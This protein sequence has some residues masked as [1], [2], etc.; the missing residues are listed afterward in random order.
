MKHVL[1]TLLL[2]TLCATTSFGQTIKSLGYNT[3]NGQVIYSGTNTLAFTNSTTIGA[4]DAMNF[5]VTP[6]EITV[7]SS[8]AGENILTMPIDDV[9]IFSSAYYWNDPSIRAAFGFATNLNTLWTATNSSNARSA[10][11]LGATWLTNTNV[12]NFRTAIGLGA[13]N[14]VT[15]EAIVGGSRS[16]NVVNGEFMGAW[17]F[18]DSVSFGAPNVVRTNVGLPLAALTNTSN[19]TAMRALS[20]STNTNHPFSGSISV[21]GTNNTNTLVFTN[22]ILRE[23]TTP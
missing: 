4:A 22:G 2:A 12:T 23:V 1:F 18:D 17:Y 9:P 21:T 19:V 20:G 16:I 14:E 11:G 7:Y 6:T 5:T 8:A 15:F 13:S 3:T 10:V